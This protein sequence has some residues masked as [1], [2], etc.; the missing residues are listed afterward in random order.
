MDFLGCCARRFACRT[1]RAAG[2]TARD[3]DGFT[4]FPVVVA[5]LE[6]EL[7]RD[8]DVDKYEEGAGK[9]DDEEEDDERAEADKRTFASVATSSDTRMTA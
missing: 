5:A 4:L 6:A 9:D 3:E 1:W 8:V 2:F 7:Y